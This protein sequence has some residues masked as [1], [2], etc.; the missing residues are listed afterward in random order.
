[1][2]QVID[3]PSLLDSIKDLFTML[4]GQLF[5]GAYTLILVHF[6]LTPLCAI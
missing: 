3:G 5:N 4:S 2:E 6:Y 1:M